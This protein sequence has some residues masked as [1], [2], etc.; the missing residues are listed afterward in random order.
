MNNKLLVSAISITSALALMGGVTFALFSSTASNAGNTFGAGTMTLAINGVTGTASTPVFT[1]PNKVPGFTATQ[2]LILS[3]TGTVGAGTT[4]L[5]GINI[6]P[7]TAGNLGEVLTLTLYNDSNNNGVLDVGTDTVINSDHLIDS[8]WINKPLGF[9]LISS[10]QHQVFAV[11]SF[12]S[13]TNPTGN[14]N[15]YQ[16]KS[17]TFD[18]NFR[19]DQ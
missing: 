1:L 4:V 14:I 19:A 11:L 17:V 12:D 13:D 8:T 10:E 2:M 16:G 9:G 18:F 5:T 7:N 3:N 6:N 15:N